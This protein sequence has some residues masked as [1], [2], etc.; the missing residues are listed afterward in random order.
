MSGPLVG[1]EHIECFTFFV[2]G[3]LYS[4]Y[5]FFFFNLRWRTYRQRTDSLSPYFAFSTDRCVCVLVT[6]NHCDGHTRNLCIEA[7]PSFLFCFFSRPFS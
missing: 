7:L 2:L 5:S 6:V 4:L 3:D 1:A